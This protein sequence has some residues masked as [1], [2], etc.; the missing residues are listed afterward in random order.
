[1]LPASG[2]HLARSGGLVPG[3]EAIVMARL[4]KVVLFVLA[5]AL[6]GGSAWQIGVG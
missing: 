1:M 3:V 2:E 5:L 6:A 4:V